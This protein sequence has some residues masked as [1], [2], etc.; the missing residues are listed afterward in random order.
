MHN[1]DPIVSFTFDDF[2]RSA[3]LMGGKILREHAAIGTYFMSFGLMG[4]VAPTGEIFS[5]DDLPELIAQ[6]HELGCHTFD[7]CHSWE[8]PPGEFERSVIRNQEALERYLPG[9]KFQTLS[10]PISVPRAGT[11]RCLARHFVC[12]RGGG[13]FLNSMTADLNYLNAFFIEQSRENPAAIERVIEENARRKGWLIFATHDISNSP[14]AFGC[15][16]GLFADVV[17]WARESGARILPVAEALKV[18]QREG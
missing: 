7:H 2:P 9:R 10:Y 12:C 8:T 5:A 6:G 1:V 14:T 13:Q 3:L 17:N 4:K 15:T 16:P 11:K 18:S